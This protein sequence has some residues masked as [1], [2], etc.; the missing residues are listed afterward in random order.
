MFIEIYF[1]FVIVRSE[2]LVWSIREEWVGDTD[3]EISG[4]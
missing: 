4:I 1:R 3:L 2:D